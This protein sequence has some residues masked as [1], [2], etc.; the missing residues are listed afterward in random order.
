[1]VRISIT[2]LLTLVGTLLVFVGMTTAI[3]A[4]SWEPVCS[5][6][7]TLKDPCLRTLVSLELESGGES[8]ERDR[9]MDWCGEDELCRVQ[10][11]DARPAGD[12][13]SERA[14]CELWTPNFR[15][16]CEQGIAR[17]HSPS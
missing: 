2:G 13:W 17:R 7:A 9:L 4:A 6:S 12:A 15:L 5:V 8:V 16:T 10:V 14:L 1:M 11:L 3:P